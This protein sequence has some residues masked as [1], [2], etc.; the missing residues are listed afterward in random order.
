M[1]AMLTFFSFPKWSFRELRGMCPGSVGGVRTHRPGARRPQCGFGFATV[2]LVVD[3]GSFVCEL[4]E[5][6]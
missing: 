6:K 5:L 3:P 1:K 2:E 4:R